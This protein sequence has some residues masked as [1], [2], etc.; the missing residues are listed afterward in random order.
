MELKRLRI[1]DVCEMTKLSR[2]TIYD[3]MRAGQFPQSHKDGHCSLWWYH[4]VQ[5]YLADKLTQ[6]QSA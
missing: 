6:Q 2:T 1:N 4:E 5:A 3:R